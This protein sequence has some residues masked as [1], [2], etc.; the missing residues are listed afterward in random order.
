MQR[1]HQATRL[2]EWEKGADYCQELGSYQFL[3][4]IGAFILAQNGW[5]FL[6]EA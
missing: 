6:S 4:V 1:H 3:E 5:S 2:L